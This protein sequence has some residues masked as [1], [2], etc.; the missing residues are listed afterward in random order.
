MIPE[1]LDSS[2]IVSSTEE[3][4]PGGSRDCS[5][6]WVGVF[7]LE[8]PVLDDVE[9]ERSRPVAGKSRINCSKMFTI[10]KHKTLKNQFAKNILYET[11]SQQK[12]NIR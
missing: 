1:G 10:L 8:E 4:M 12:T 7:R 3:A 6:V 9:L 11:I 5:P 2:W